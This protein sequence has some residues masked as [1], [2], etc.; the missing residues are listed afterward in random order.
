M[1]LLSVQAPHINHG[2]ADVLRE[3]M[4]IEDVVRGY[5]LVAEKIPEIYGPN[6]QN[7]PKYGK[8]TYGWAALNLG[9]YTA[10][11]LQNIS[12]CD[13]IRSVTTVIE[14]LRKKIKDI[15]PIVKAKAANFIE[16]P[17][18]YLDA[19]K[20]RGLGFKSQVSFEEGLDKTIDW[21]KTN[22]NALAGLAQRYIAN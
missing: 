9:S 22:F 11:E 4:Y 13:K 19:S 20:L 14:M 2:N 16:I 10:E 12:R 1:C 5:L 18:Q 17:D 21:Y 6:N 15:E 8:E 7:M 3:Y